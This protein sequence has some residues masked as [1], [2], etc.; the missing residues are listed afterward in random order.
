[1][2]YLLPYSAAIATNAPRLLPTSTMRELNFCNIVG[3]IKLSLIQ[4]SDRNIELFSIIHSNITKNIWHFT[5]C[6]FYI[7]DIVDVDH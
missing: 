5:V 6:K 1:M 3:F 4:S 7:V 2:V